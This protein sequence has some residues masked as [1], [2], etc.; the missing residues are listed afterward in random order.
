MGSLLIV[1]GKVKEQT[2]TLCKKGRR[3]GGW[4]TG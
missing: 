3:N 1:H 2:T 4:T